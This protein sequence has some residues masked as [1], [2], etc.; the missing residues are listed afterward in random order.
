M[1]GRRAKLS[2]V[3]TVPYK[4]ILAEYSD[5]EK[6]KFCFECGICTAWR[7]CNI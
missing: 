5:A 4:E 7:K 2:A 6:L 3:K 1:I